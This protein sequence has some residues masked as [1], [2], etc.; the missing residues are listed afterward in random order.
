MRQQQT[1]K[2]DAKAKRRCCFFSGFQLFLVEGLMAGCSRSFC[3]GLTFGL[4]WNLH[5]PV[6]I[7]ISQIETQ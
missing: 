6:Q 2:R 5:L 1:V 3:E 7:A 4:D